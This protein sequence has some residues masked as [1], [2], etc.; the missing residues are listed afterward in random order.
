MKITNKN[1][2][3]IIKEEIEAFLSEQEFIDIFSP[4]YKNRIRQRA[5]KDFQLRLKDFAA[6][7]PN[8]LPRWAMQGYWRNIVKDEFPE[9]EEHFQLNQSSLGNLGNSHQ[10]N[11][12]EYHRYMADALEIEQK[13]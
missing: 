5:R 9:I 7:S 13:Q 3:Q 11:V 12:L 2:K 1:L 10:E 4:E 8:I 6:Y